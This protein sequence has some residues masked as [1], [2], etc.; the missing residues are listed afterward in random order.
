[1]I[2]C[3]RKLKIK[4]EVYEKS[5]CCN[6]SINDSGK[7]N[8]CADFRRGRA[9]SRFGC[10]GS[11]KQAVGLGAENQ[12]CPNA[13]GCTRCATAETPAGV[14]DAPFEHNDDTTM[15]TVTKNILLA[16]GRT[17]HVLRKNC[18]DAKVGIAPTG[19]C[20]LPKAWQPGRSGKGASQ[21]PF[22]LPRLHHVQYLVG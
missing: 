20:C 11:G 21:V 9:G 13:G 17:V 5:I 2:F 7:R 18:P 3:M 10:G 4:G 12:V 8:P 6:T 14:M 22:A 16:H 1:M 19:D 15:M